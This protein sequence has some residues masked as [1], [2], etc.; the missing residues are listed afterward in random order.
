MDLES[1]RIFQ[2]VAAELSITQAAVRLGRAP[3]NVTTRIQQLEADIGTALFV[4]TGKR[5]ALA[6]AGE[7]FLGYAQ[8]L[9]ALEAEARHVVT[10]GAYGGQLHIG[11]M[12][13]TAASRLPALLAAYHT[14]FAQTQ[15]ELTTGPSRGLLE[16]VRNGALD[17]AFAALPAEFD[18]AAAL[19][20]LGLSSRPVWQEELLLL[21]PATEGAVADPAA[22]RTRALAAFKPGC[23]YRTLAEQRLG[24][25][26]RTDWRIQEMGS[27]HAMVACVA[28][29]ACV[30]V[31]PRS[32]LALGNA[33][34]ALQTLA[35][36]DVATHLVWRTHYDVPAFRHLRELLPRPPG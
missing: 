28:A 17:C 21:L 22:L 11:A 32:V 1:L 30:T 18:E 2:T 12:E 3:S 6:R 31:L 13:S 34:S 36:G 29:G 23:T 8:R 5:L 4:R 15:L 24:I 7:H 25:A 16:M 14:R 10:G 20:E 27:Y 19:A 9:L 33:P 35:L 26:G